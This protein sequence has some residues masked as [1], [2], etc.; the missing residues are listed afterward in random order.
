M[1]R[2]W[3]KRRRSPWAWLGG[4]VVLAA[5]SLALVALFSETRRRAEA[6][7]V[8][9]VDGGT[10]PKAPGL[11]TIETDARRHARAVGGIV[12]LPDGRPAAG[13]TV[14]IHRAITGWP[15][16]RS[17]PI[18]Q[19]ITGPSGTF[20]FRV[21]RREGMLLEYGH[22]DWAGGIDQVPLANVPVRLQLQQGFDLFGVVTNPVGAPV[23]N[24]R[25]AIESVL[26]DDRRAQAVTT[27]ANGAYRFANLRAGPVRLVA[28]HEQWYPAAV[29]VVVVGDQVRRDLT[30][31]RPGMAPLRGRVTSLVS[32]APVAGAAVELLPVNVRPG[33]ADPIT[34]E[35]AADGTFLLS[36]LP[37]GNMRIFV[38]HP[39]HGAISKTLAIGTVPAELGFELPPRSQLSGQLVVEDGGTRFLGGELLQFLDSAGQLDFCVVAGDGSF[40][41]DAPL[42]PGWATARLIDSDLVFVRSLEDETA[43]RVD[44]SGRTEAELAVVPS[45]V[46]RGRVVDER[47]APLAGATVSR[48]RLLAESARILGNAA[49]GLDL[50]QFSRQL[51]QLF[52]DE[53]DE[54]LAIADADGRFA[55][56]GRKPGPLLVRF[57]L[58]GRGT[59]WASIVVPGD[60]E[61]TELDPVVLPR[62][63]TISGRV[64]RAGRGLAGAAVTAVGPESQAMTVTRDGGT[65]V[66]ED[67][68]PGEYRIRARLPSM[69]N[70]SREYVVTTESE[71][72]SADV[73]VVL[74]TGRTVRGIVS[75]SDGQPVPSALVTVRGAVG[76][77][78][79]T[80]SGGDFLLELPEREVE[81]QISLADRSRLR[82]IS[83]P[84][85]MQSLNVQLDTPSTC[86]L[87]AQVSG[88]PG[89]QRLAGALVRCTALDDPTA[90]SRAR[91]IELQNGQLRWSLC[92][93]GRVRVEIWADG[94]APFVVERQFAASKDH[95]L[96]EVLLEPGG[97]LAGRVLDDQ[98]EPV[99]N[100][101][102]WLGEESDVDVFE[103]SVHSAGDG[104]FRIGGVTT[105]SAQLIVR[106]TGFAPRAVDLVLPHDVLSPTPLVVTLE[107]GATIEVQ[108]AR[109]SEFEGS[110]VQLRRH[111][112][113]VASTD[114][115]EAGR[116]WF[117]NRSAGAYAVVLPGAD[118][119]PTEVVVQPGEP[120]VRV[121]LR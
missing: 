14:T 18:D 62:G 30:F 100:A 53:R 112:R 2:T 40:R 70:G 110:F 94:F 72:P 35:T 57:D 19:A 79:L 31:E 88:L 119:P 104:S 1:T 115:D 56:R 38:R 121:R 12:L 98:G 93:I 91:W 99:A 116:A 5:L 44:E 114:F 10:E 6:V 22:K 20:E 108:L 45:R 68:L 82:V 29:P 24:A 67:L 64:L 75:G 13:A 58:P 46:V 86:S 54:V 15:E 3:T 106:A 90:E 7:P 43:V 27:A 111:G 21:A 105:R 4:L 102:V 28:R 118:L 113:V 65:F 50:G 95:D 84:T 92:P 48:T 23:P 85:G 47:R 49:V 97:V 81:L 51:V 89:K 66:F 76:Q 78:T 9:G 33:L 32:Q 109:R 71:R 101:A 80:D 87:L 37:R 39:D 77:T 83:V 107:R 74:D 96:G 26:S 25:V 42:S 16:W 61:P 59:R 117:P 8:V 120:L 52:D 69:P 60:P 63:A 36:G 73:V 34:A 11:V 103:P 17:Q 55:I 41:C